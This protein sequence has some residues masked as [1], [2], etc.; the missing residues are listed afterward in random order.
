MRSDQ[1]RR[2]AAL[3][4]ASLFCATSGHASLAIGEYALSGSADGAGTF[5]VDDDLDVYL[6]G[7]LIFTE[8]VAPGTPRAHQPIRFTANVGDTIRLTVRDSYGVCV[9]LNRV[10]I[11]DAF[12]RYAVADPGFAEVC[13]FPP[14]DRGV[15]YDVTLPIPTL[16]DP[17]AFSEV[18]LPGSTLAGVVPGPG[19]QLYGVTYDGGVNDKGTIFR[20]DPS[21]ATVT[22]LHSFDGTDGATPYFE[23]TLDPASGKFYGTTFQGGQG[24]NLGTIFR[25]D[26]ATNALTTLKADFSSDY[27]P[28]GLVLVDGFL[29]G[30]LTYSY[31]AVFRIG[32]DGSDFTVIHRFAGF[33]SLPQAL[34][35]GPPVD[36]APY[37]R[38]LYGMTTYGGIVC[39]PNYPGC[40]TI[41]RLAPIL[42]GET[43]E[44]F[45]TLYEFQSP[46]NQFHANFPQGNLIWS[47]NGSLYGTTAYDLFR[48]DPGDLPF[49]WT[50]GRGVN[51]S[52][53]EGSDQRL[54][55]ADYSGGTEG[56]GKVISLNLDGTLVKPLSTFSYTTGSKS[57]GPYGRLYRN[58][59]GTVF[60]TTEYT[61]DPP[62]RGV[63][64]AIARTGP[65]ANAQSVTTSVATPVGV[66]LTGSD[67]GGKLLT[68]AVVTNPQHGTLSG[69]APNLTYTPNGSYAGT[70]SFTFAVLNAQEISLPVT[71][72]IDVESVSTTI[73][74]LG[75]SFA[76]PDGSVT[77]TVPP[78]AVIVP[79]DFMITSSPTSIYGIGTPASLVKVVS[80]AP[81]GLVFLVPVELR[82]RWPD[83]APENGFVDGLGVDEGTLRVYRNGS[84]ITGQCRTPAYQTGT[85]TTECCDVVANTWAVNVS[86]FSEYVLDADVCATYEKPKLTLGKLLAPQGDDTLTFTGMFVAPAS[87]PDPDLKGVT[88]TLED[89]SGL[90]AEVALPAGSYDKVTKTGWK[91]NK[92]RTSW[93]WL[94]PKDGALSGFVKAALTVRK[95][96]LVVVLKGQLGSYVATPPAA[97]AIRLPATAG[98]AR[99]DFGTAGHSCVVKNKGKTLSCQ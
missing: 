56:A 7:T 34:T 97:I 93:T 35:P 12:G 37:P 45:E 88:I 48:L 43:D 40:G 38:R 25:F 82:F 99:A 53:I 68:F 80:L 71:V 69:A 3:L 26:P 16:A 8:N 89:A 36:P 2:V 94:H 33:S 50:G 49:V 42:A 90:L 64:F 60:G 29:Y 96:K 92:K 78:G 46:T 1:P 85:C 63:I 24:N 27:A 76:L 14:G 6:N 54:Y 62:E 74:P 75:G 5:D 77:V 72:L 44:K 18:A 20:Y 39:H 22:T 61:I 86:S 55:L 10:F 51:L 21:S 79:T 65:V 57:Y 31:G 84:A 58:A 28:R 87:P 15:V 73:G 11:T 81:A 41:F 66:T 83:V 4:L 67:P 47:S 98:C 9:V 13:G 19:G 32:L 17:P 91:V 59:V 52:A 30:V 70:D 23:L 95:A